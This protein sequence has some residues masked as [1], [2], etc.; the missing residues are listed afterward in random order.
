M[1]DKNIEI[2]SN[3][4]AVTLQTKYQCPYETGGRL[5]QIAL[6]ENVRQR[7]RNRLAA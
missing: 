2:P 7:A 6:I 5:Q 3:L 1:V 4:L